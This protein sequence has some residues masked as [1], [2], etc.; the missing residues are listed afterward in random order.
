L[1]HVS[2]AT[3]TRPRHG[4]PTY[5]SYPDP[6]EHPGTRQHPAGGRQPPPPH[7]H[8]QAARPLPGSP[9]SRHPRPAQRDHRRPWHRGRLPDPDPE[10]QR[11][12]RSHGHPPP[13]QGQSRRLGGRRVPLAERQRRDDRRLLD[14][15]S[16]P[17][18]GMATSTTSTGT[19]SPKTP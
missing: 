4:P 9:P 13:R 5:R 18:P 19:T 14:R 11:T 2:Y 12:D 17:K 3:K 1:A 10:R 8:G 15:R 16:P 6:R 7:P